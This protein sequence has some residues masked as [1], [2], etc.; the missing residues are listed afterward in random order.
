MTHRMNIAIDGPA[1]AG[2]STV[3][4]LVARELGYVYIDTGAMYR[5]VSLHMTRVS[6]RPD[7]TDAL[8]E[9]MKRLRIELRPE[10]DRQFV[11]LNG[12]DVTDA[13][14][15]SEMSRLAS[16]YAQVGVVR[17]QLVEMQRQMAKCKGVVMD[18]RDIGTHVL[19]DAE[20]KWFITASVEERAR[21]RYAEWKDKEVASLE[22][23]IREIADRD[24]QDETR[25][26]SPL[27]Q[28]EDAVLLDTTGMTIDD[29]VRVI[30]ERVMIRK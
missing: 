22:Q 8:A 7:E 2:K 24:R 16:L 28:A 15:T 19:P 26:V 6:I 30:V 25:E 18:G 3:A 12:E 20:M 29:V 17:E 21:R 11:F 23:F 4:R 10:A 9:E 1:G 14:R 27:K 13:I 5:A